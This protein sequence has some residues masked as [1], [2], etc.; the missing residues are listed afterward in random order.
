MLEA[1]IINVPKPEKDPSS[2]A[3]FKPI[4]L[5]NSDIKMYA[6]ILA[7]R[8]LEITSHLMGSDQV[9][10]VKGQEASMIKQVENSGMPSQLLALD[11]LS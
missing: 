5:L 3:N 2:P 1:I 8:L 9:G 7:S 4:S 6:K 11:A 10:I